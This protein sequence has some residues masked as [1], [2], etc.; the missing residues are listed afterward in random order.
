VKPCLEKEKKKS[1][2]PSPAQHK[3]TM[4]A[5]S[6]NPSNQEAKELNLGSLKEQ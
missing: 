2:V 4:V 1:W 5:H 6:S 3:V